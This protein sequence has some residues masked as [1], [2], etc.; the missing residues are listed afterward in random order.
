MRD[1]YFIDIDWRQIQERGRAISGDVCLTG[2][3]D[4]RVS[5]VLC[6]GVGSGI[7]ANVIASTIASMALNY[8]LEGEDPIRTAKSIVETF[9]RGEKS[10]DVRQSTFT[11]ITIE[12]G[13]DVTI[14]E[15][16]NPSIILTRENKIIAIPKKRCSFKTGNDVSLEVYLTQFK[17]LPEDRVVVFTDGITLSGCAT[18]RMPKGWEQKGVIN[19]VEKLI[20]ENP[21][22]S[23]SELSSMVVRN[24]EMNDL[25]LVKNDCSC[26]SIYFR[27][28][29][30]ILICTGP[31]F[32]STKD[33]ELGEIVKNFD[34]SVIIS[35]GT[36]AQIIARETEREVSVVLKRDVSM[37]PPISRMEG[38]LMVT[39]GV[40]TLS[41]V[42]LML[43]SIDSSEIRQQGI[44]ARY[45]RYLLSHDE[46][47]FVIGNGINTQHHDPNLPVEL[48]FRRSVIKDIGRILESRFMKRVTMRYL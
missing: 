24:S 35:G 27:K 20:A 13:E 8:A 23:S 1:N 6:D 47:Y 43:E 41:K 36:T 11:I 10:D 14:I 3:R 29:R 19:F 26:A 39:E 34:G 30:K 46:I 37:L 9:A 4:S 25:F 15:F 44:D 33:K 40:L 2:K 22:I 48:E 5:L 45:A 32:S 42:R 12:N 21:L 31:P 18:H 28:P 16:E 7:K 38:T 17:S